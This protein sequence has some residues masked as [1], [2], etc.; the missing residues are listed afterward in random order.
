MVDRVM[1]IKEGARI[2]VLSPIVRGR[3]GEYRKELDG[4]LRS[5]YTRVKVDGEMR[6]LEEA[7]VLDKRKKH[8]IDVVVDRLVVKDGIVGRLADSL[9]V[10]ARLSGGIVKVEAEGPKGPRE[11][12]FNEKLSCVDC[13][14][15]YPEITPTTFSFNSPHGACPEC[16]GLGEKFYFD[17]DL[18]V[19]DKDLTLERGAVEPWSRRAGYY[20]QILSSL[21]RHYGFSLLKPFKSLQD[22][23]KELILYGSGEEEIEFEYR[24]DRNRYTFFETFEG[25]IPKEEIE[26]YMNAQPCPVCKGSRLKREALFVKVEGRSVHDIVKMSIKDT[27]KFF[28][29]IKL[30]RTRQEIARRILKEITERL[31]FLKNVGLDYITLERP[32]ATLAGGEG[33]RIR[34][35]TQIGSSLVGV[36][37]ILDEPSIGLHQ[38]DNRRLLAALKR[39]RDMGNTVLVVEHDEA[40]IRSADYVVDMGPGAG[41]WGGE[42]VSTG[43]HQDIMEDARSV[44]GK[45]LSGLLEIPVP[46]KR[47]KPDRRRLTLKG[48]RA[49]NLKN[50]DVEIPVGLITCVTGV[51]GSGKSTLVVDTLYRNLARILYKS[52]EKGKRWAPS[53]R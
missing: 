7:I 11:L 53:N 45:Y 48:L 47:K 20:R 51:S 44:T 16:N 32:A 22:R 8:Y 43:T 5:G 52:R 2:L 39:L 42:V 38:R 23:V 46:E 4:L 28:T 24:K 6:G 30:D 37:Y 9:E 31:G 35:A 3:K 27:L 14:V 29:A 33:Q 36:L 21:A 13:A 26:K 18:V 19:P 40:T 25:V 49:N 41:E 17:P 34:L 10:S 15:S 12:F 50:I 1:E